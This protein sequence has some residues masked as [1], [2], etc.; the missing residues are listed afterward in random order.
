MIQLKAF[1]GVFGSP[2]QGTG[3]LTGALRDFK[4]GDVSNAYHNEIS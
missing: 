3:A 2:G 4:V 1:P